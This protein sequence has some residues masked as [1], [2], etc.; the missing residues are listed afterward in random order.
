MGIATSIGIFTYVHDDSEVLV[1]NL[2][3]SSGD[4]S[5]NDDFLF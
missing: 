5:V 2:L 4:E 1:M 3:K